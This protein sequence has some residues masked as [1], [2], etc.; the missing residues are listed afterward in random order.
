MAVTRPLLSMGSAHVRWRSRETV[1]ARPGHPKARQRNPLCPS[2]HRAA[3][4][5]TKSFGQPLRECRSPKIECAF[6]AYCQSLWQHSLHGIHRR[7]Q[8]CGLTPRSR[9]GPT[10][11]HQGPPGGTRYIFASR[12][13]ASCRWSRL[14][15][16]VR[17]RPGNQCSFSKRL[18]QGLRRECWSGNGR[19]FELRLSLQLST[20]CGRPA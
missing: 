1:C 3:H 7:S 6:L 13:L 10:A 19:L 8:Q 17:Q 14:S 11:G 12:A 5:A 2:L 9:R 16:N 20:A 18:G 15:S 4:G